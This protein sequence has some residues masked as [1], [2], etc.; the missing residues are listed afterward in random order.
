MARGPI[1]LKLAAE[2]SVYLFRSACAVILAAIAMPAVAQPLSDSQLVEA[3]H[4]GFAAVGRVLPD[5]WSELA[6]TYAK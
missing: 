5:R 6:A 2:A 1:C 3:L 4:G